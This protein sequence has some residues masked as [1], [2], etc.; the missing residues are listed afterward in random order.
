M[1]ISFRLL[2]VEVILPYNFDLSISKKFQ[3]SDSK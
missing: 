3:L 1:D 2:Y